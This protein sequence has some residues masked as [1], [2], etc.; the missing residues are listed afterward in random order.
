MSIR[1]EAITAAAKVIFDGGPIYGVSEEM[2]AEVVGD[3]LA[4]V[5]A[6][7]GERAAVY[8]RPAHPDDECDCA[9][10][11]APFAELLEGP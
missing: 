4:R 8:R 5:V 9:W 7:A 1:T 11:Y 6:L 10:H 2:A 3:V